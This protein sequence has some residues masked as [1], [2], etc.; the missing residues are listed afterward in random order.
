MRVAPS[1][2]CKGKA[3]FQYSEK[4]GRVF[5]KTTSK[6]LSLRNTLTY[7]RG[8]LPAAAAGLRVLVWE[9]IPA[10]LYGLVFFL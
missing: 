7:L 2:K 3:I 1:P 4:N 8:K 6:I 9:N 10:Y 5:Y